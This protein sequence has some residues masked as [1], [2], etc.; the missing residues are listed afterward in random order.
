MENNTEK[1][2]EILIRARYPLIYTV[3]FE[4]IRVIQSI[5]NISKRRNK[6]LFQWSIT[7]GLEKP[8]GSFL[9]EFKDPVKVLECILQMDLNGV[10]VLKDFHHYMN[11]P[12]IIRR[13]RDLG[14]SLKLTLKSVIFLSPIL[15]SD[16]NT[17]KGIILMIIRD[18][19]FFI[20]K[21]LLIFVSCQMMYFN[22]IPYH[23]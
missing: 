6:K 18:K 23:G 7:E 21:I 4:E 16:A 14:H 5:K 10:F 11:D 19:N 13:L 20:K 2:I 9:A 1:K 3:S 17:M 12:V 22:F 8:D 15:T